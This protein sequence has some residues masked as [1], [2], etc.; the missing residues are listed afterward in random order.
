M[1]L[2]DDEQVANIN[3]QSITTLIELP[4]LIPGI[5]DVNIVIEEFVRLMNIKCEIPIKEVVINVKYN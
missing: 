1:T 4:R 5:F 3:H 2:L